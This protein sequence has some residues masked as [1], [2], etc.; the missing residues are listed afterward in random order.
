MVQ[1]RRLVEIFNHYGVKG[2][3]N[4][5]SGLLNCRNLTLPNDPLGG[6][7][8]ISSAELPTLYAGHEVAAHTLEHGFLP[9]FDDETVIRV[10]EEDR[11]ALSRLVGYEVVGMAYP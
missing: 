11:Q 3:F 6:R 10:V 2:T 1:D 5:A 9:A 8:T 4:V 7:K